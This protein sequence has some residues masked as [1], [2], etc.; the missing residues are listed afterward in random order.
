M[1]DLKCDK[2]E[3][4]GFGYDN[5]IQGINGKMDV[6][7]CTKCNGYGRVNN[8]SICDGTGLDIHAREVRICYCQ[9][10]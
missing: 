1:L 2:C 5:P 4:S 8:C 10:R 3:G 7:P 9:K 6:G